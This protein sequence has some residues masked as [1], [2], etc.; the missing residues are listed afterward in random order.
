MA[1]QTN[2][3]AEKILEKEFKVLDHGFVRLIDY[4]GGD[5]RIVEAARVSYGKGT[6][7][8]RQDKGLIDYLLRNEHTSP[9]EQ[10]SFTFHVKMPIFVAR[11]WVR[12]RTARMNEISG[13][14]SVMTDEFYLPKDHN[15]HLQNPKNRQGRD[16]TRPAPPAVRKQLRR[17]MAEHHEQVYAHYQQMLNEDISRELARIDLPLSLYTEFYWQNDLHNIF[18]FLKLRLSDHAQLEIREYAKV[19]AKIVKAVAP[20]AWESF[21]RHEL[22]GARLSAEEIVAVRN[23]IGGR[24]T[25][26]SPRAE[27]TLKKKLDLE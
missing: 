16:E 23:L 15:I 12:H 7:T 10:V 4:L 1:H 2:P 9:F 25:G 27:D 20:Y 21:E 3:R 17:T 11:Q 13:R 5:R 8:V 6:K 19:M 26:L 22:K 18:R 24:P 14:Y